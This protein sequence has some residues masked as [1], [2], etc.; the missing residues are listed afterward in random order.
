MCQLSDPSCGCLQVG[1]DGHLLNERA[2]PCLRVG[3]PPRHVLPAD[4]GPQGA[5]RHAHGF[6]L[7]RLPRPVAVAIEADRAPP[8]AVDRDGGADQRASL[9]GA[10]HDLPVAQDPLPS[11]RKPPRDARSSS[12][13]SAPALPVPWSGSAPFAFEERHELRVIGGAVAVHEGARHLTGA[14]EALQDVRD[15]VGP[16]PLCE[17]P[18]CGV[19]GSL[20]DPFA[21]AE[22]ILSQLA[23]GDVGQHTLPGVDAVRALHEERMVVHPHHRAVRAHEAVLDVERIAGLV[24]AR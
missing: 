19:A 17:E 22:R 3:E 1:H 18:L 9:E 7:G 10:V 23:L 15:G 12:V 2:E 16:R 14:P 20:Q 11:V 24:R 13:F 6:D 21:S 8:P 5:G 4:G